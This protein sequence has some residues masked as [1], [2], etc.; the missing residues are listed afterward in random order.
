MDRP[1]KRVVEEGQ[2]DD[3]E[4]EEE[5]QHGQEDYWQE[6]RNHIDWDESSEEED[7][8][9]EE[10]SHDDALEDLTIATAHTSL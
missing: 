5:G 10:D 3:D 9:S 1:V 2:D 6:N 4:E 8:D 7:E